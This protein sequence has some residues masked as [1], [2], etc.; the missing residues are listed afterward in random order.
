MIEVLLAV[1]YLCADRSD[2]LKVQHSHSSDT[3]LDVFVRHAVVYHTSALI[4]SVQPWIR[5]LSCSHGLRLWY[6]HQHLSK[7]V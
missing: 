5:L 2:W 6:L 4:W 1:A 3:F 7:G